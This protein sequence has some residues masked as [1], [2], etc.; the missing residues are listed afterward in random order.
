V[1]STRGDKVT[2]GHGDKGK[3]KDTTMQCS[4]APTN[5]L[6]GHVGKVTRGHGERKMTRV[7]PLG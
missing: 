2:W 3:Y 6:R 4:R 1:R 7:L 5:K